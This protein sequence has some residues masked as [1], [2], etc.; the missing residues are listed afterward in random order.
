[1]K[2]VE[3]S[4]QDLLRLYFDDIADSRPLPRE[5]EVELAARI[6]EGDM[7][8]RNELVHANLRF[9]I[10]V[11]KQYQNRGLSLADLIGAGNAGLMTANTTSSASITASMAKSR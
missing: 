2:D 10:D 3:S 5:K 4:E 9:V 8:A 11:A 1:M 7:E 6:K